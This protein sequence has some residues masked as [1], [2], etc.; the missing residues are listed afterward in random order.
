MAK[1]DYAQAIADFD[2]ALRVD[3]DDAIGRLGL[4]TILASCPDD[5]LRDGRRALELATRACE[6]LRWQDPYALNSLAEAHAELG[7]FPQAVRRQSE[8]IELIPPEI[9]AGG[10][11]GLSWS[12]S[13]EVAHPYRFPR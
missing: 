11:T 3:P 5:Q 9:P 8:A 6:R 7:Q 1:K 10:A 12:T 4:A 2:E 13:R